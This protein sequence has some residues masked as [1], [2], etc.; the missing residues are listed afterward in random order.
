MDNQ[1]NTIAIS[2]DSVRKEGGVVVLSLKEYN[3]LREGRIPTC[4]LEGKEADELDN[5]VKEGLEDHRAGK[6]IKATSLKDALE[7]YD[8]E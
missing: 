1:N 3:E 7:T 4:Y 5:L 6:T 2:K 8:R